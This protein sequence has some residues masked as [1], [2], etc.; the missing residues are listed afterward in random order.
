MT[1]GSSDPAAADEPGLSAWFLSPHERGNPATEIDRRRGGDVAYTD[2]NDVRVLVHGAEYFARLLAELERPAGG[3]MGPLHGLARRS[4]RTARRSRDRGRPGPGRARR[5]RRPRAWPRLA[6]P[7]RRGALQRAGEPAPRRDG[8][9]GR[10][11]GAAR[12]AGAPRRQPPPEAVRRPPPGHAGS[13]MSPSPAAST[14]ATAGATTSVIRATSRR[15][16]STPATDHDRRGTTSSWRSAA[17]RSAIWRGR[18]ASGGRTRPRSTTATR[19]APRRAPRR[20][21]AS[22]SRPVAADA[23]RPGAVRAAT[24][25]RCCAR[26]RR[27]DRRFPFAPDG[28]RSIARAYLKAFDRATSLVYVEDQYLWSGAAARFLGD[29]LR[30]EPR[31]HLVAVVPRYPDQDGLLS[32]PPYR[33]GQQQAIEQ[34]TTAGGDR[35]AFFDLEAPSGL[36]DLRALQGLRDRRRVDDRRQRQP[37][38]PLVD[39]R[40]GAVVRRHRPAPRRARAPRP[41]RPW[42]RGPHARP[43]HPPPAVARAP[44]ARRRRRR[45]PDRRRRGDRGAASSAADL[46]AWRTDPAVDR[47]RPVGCAGTDR[48]RCRGGPDGGPNRSTAP[49][50][51]PTVDRAPCAAPDASA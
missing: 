18:S 41:R 32:G 35:V 42:R 14:C 2:G 39:Q 11:R 1:L 6:V 34:L 29:R 23:G 47:A 31:L 46:D 40:L 22:T 21:G 26:T 36:A 5:A 17:R 20:S 16:S 10:R 25:C 9:R 12:R 28:E 43:R 13:R 45:R 49:S 33:I 24:P 48:N 7:S 8:E 3:R 50:S 38:H 19:G 37:Q 4:G 51:T 30:A 27:S 44:R 15:S